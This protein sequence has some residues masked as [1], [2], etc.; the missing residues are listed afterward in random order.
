MKIYRYRL[1]NLQVVQ[2]VVFTVHKMKIEKDKL[3]I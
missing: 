1:E 2:L 3:R